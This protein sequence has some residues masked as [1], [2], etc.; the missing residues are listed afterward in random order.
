MRKAGTEVRFTLTLA[1]MPKPL[2]A[3]YPV[4]GDRGVIV[5]PAAFPGSF[6]VRFTTKRTGQEVVW[7]CLPEHVAYC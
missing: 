1:D 4:F 3:V 2:P 5:G 6:D 7:T